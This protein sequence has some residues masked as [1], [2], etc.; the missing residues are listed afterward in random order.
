M[1]PSR[2]GRLSGSLTVIETDTDRCGT[3]DFLLM[4]HTNHV[5]ISYRFQDM[6]RH[7]SKIANISYPV[8][9]TAEGFSL[10]FCNAGLAKELE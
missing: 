1:D 3:Y 4:I 5:P 2:P 8:Y 10:E 9:L 6:A 7:W